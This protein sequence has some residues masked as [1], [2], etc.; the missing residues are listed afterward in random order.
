M[1]KKR[2]KLQ[3][4]LVLLAVWGM[5]FAAM[6]VYEQYFVSSQ[7]A[8]LKD[9]EFHVLGRMAR[10]LNDQVQR[11]QLSTQSFVQLAAGDE[12]PARGSKQHKQILAE[13][14][15]LYLPG[16]WSGAS[17]APPQAQAISVAMQ[18]SVINGP[19]FVPLQA[20]MRGL[21]LTLSCLNRDD[22]KTLEKI[23]TLPL[24]S[25]IQS[26]FLPLGRDF[27]EVLIADD[28]G[29]VLFQKPSAGPRITNLNPLVPKGATGNAPSSDG[30][31]SSQKAS[32]S[33]DENPA[34]AG[35]KPKDS[36]SAQAATISPTKLDDT[37]FFTETTLAGLDYD[38]FSVP[39]RIRLRGIDE[40]L[41][42]IVSG[43]R[44]KSSV[45]TDSHAIPY[46]TLIWATLIFV[47]VVSLSWPFA[48]LRYMSTTER[49]TPKDAWFLVLAMFLAAASVTLM[50]LNLS[51]TSLAREHTDEILRALA[52]DIK[53]NFQVE[54]QQA[55]EQIKHLD[56]DRDPQLEKEHQAKSG[57][58]IPEYLSLA[59]PSFYPYFDIA[60]WLDSS[61]LQVEKVDVR[62][63]PTPLVNVSPLPFFAKVLRE[64][65]WSDAE[66]PHTP[67]DAASGLLE[68][69]YID[70][71]ISLTTSQFAPVLAAAYSHPRDV[72]ALFLAVRPLSL[73]DP[74]LPPGYGFAVIDAECEVLFHSEAFRDRRENFC[75][76]SKGTAE[77][78]PWLFGGSNA[79]IDI[80]YE[81]RPERAFFCV[82]S[83][84][85][86]PGSPARLQFASGPVYLVVF[87]VPDYEVTLNLAI[88]LVCALLL[89]F[90]F[91][92]LVGAIVLASFLPKSMRIV[93][94]PQL[95]WPS[96]RNGAKYLQISAAN[97]ALL[98]TYWF[99]NP[100]TYEFPLLILT[101]L[102][103]ILSIAFPVLKLN[104]RDRT[105][106]ALGMITIVLSVVLLVASSRFEPLRDWQY[107]LVFTAIAGASAVLLS[108]SF[109]IPGRVSPRAAGISRRIRSYGRRKFDTAYTLVA[110]TVIA[111]ICVMPCIGC[112]KFAYDSV[113]EVALKHDQ[114]NVSNALLVRRDRI[115]QYY[116]QLRPGRAET[117]ATVPDLESV[118]KRIDSI[119]QQRINGAYDRYDLVSNKFT[120][121]C[122]Q[123]LGLGCQPYELA[124]CHSHFQFPR[125]PQ[126]GDP[127]V[128]FETIIAKA[129]LMFP[130]NDLGS[131]MSK[132][133]VAS[134]EPREGDEHYY[135]ELAPTTFRLVWQDWSKLLGFAVES[136]YRPWEGFRWS[137]CLL[138]VALG[139]LLGLWLSSVVRRIFLTDV[140]KLRVTEVA[141]WKQASEIKGNFIIV[142]LAKSGK[143]EWLRSIPGISTKDYFDLGIEL[144]RMAKGS[145]CPEPSGEG[146]VVVVDSFEFDLKDPA[147]NMSRLNLMEHLLY[148][149]SCWIVLVSSVDP[150][151]YLQDSGPEILTDPPNL[152]VAGKL[153]DRWAR[154]LSKFERVRLDV[155]LD[156]TFI[157]SIKRL[158]QDKPEHRDFAIA[159]RQ[160][161]K[162][163]P[164]L[165]RIGIDLLAEFDPYNPV[166]RSWV[167]NSVLDFAREYYHVLWSGLT[168]NERLALYQL[169]LD[170]WANPKNTRALQQLESKL[171]IRRAPMYRIVNESFRRFVASPEQAKEVEQWEAQQ[172]QS[173][174][175][176]LR[177]IFIGVGIIVAAWLLH[178]QAALSRDLAALLG[179]VATLF[180]AISAL[181]SRTSKP[182]TS[183]TESS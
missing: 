150:L 14:L 23:Y 84:P 81:G 16:D 163:T 26:S 167:E 75:Q 176:V 79:T 166:T 133:G 115:R 78:R 69:Y 140:R 57:I 98:L 164:A 135:D 159:V 3:K 64:A 88:I 86:V 59:N 54:M 131:E 95:I 6:F 7:E 178:S 48:K 1:L 37:S 100:R 134:T 15:R 53:S 63:A 32:P 11:A 105:L 10:E 61:G 101:A 25:W 113:S 182:A 175:R 80:S 66:T 34:P 136:R 118:N 97:F 172:Q 33:P 170:G 120:Y 72:A 148:E 156:H 107:V 149:S 142:G 65:R 13:F 168:P 103:S 129:V 154:V 9:K 91:V 180:T 40:P 157:T 126:H 181:F 104:R 82:F 47:T 177:F 153:L 58:I 160:E 38:L 171:L 132:L 52:D 151:Y 55:I 162:W 116:D 31:N 29:R 145:Y 109:R 4:L 139:F 12:L 152:E 39:V 18:C 130:S 43:L 123:N 146:Q 49:F 155:K 85:D 50:L 67:V 28:S 73:V 96:S 45:E 94:V 174:W 183:K 161:C 114:I 99:L 19:P 62:H 110:L 106:L 173:T 56:Q 76:E 35:A 46:S 20:D 22:S 89:G 119:V 128:W 42:L 71:E 60:A 165:R 111:G 30:S 87:Q 21:T 108:G 141:G 125:D 127:N 5:V 68:R 44:L 179:G 144:K 169:A 24:R 102:T 112:F 41:K 138:I 137:E 92:L 77:L 8:F 124:V 51:Y 93:D 27:D 122:D 158:V 147:S 17:D 74:V 117:S 2:D 70:P 90:Y 83:R 143:S 36:N 121:R